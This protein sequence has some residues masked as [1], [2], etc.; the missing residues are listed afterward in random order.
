[1]AKTLKPIPIPKEVTVSLADDR[2]TFKGKLDQLVMSFPPRVAIEV[3]DAAVK[4]TG[5][6]DDAQKFVGLTRALVKNCITGVSQGFTKVLEIRGMGYRAQKTKDGAV[7]FLL[8]FSH[9]ID[10]K[11]PKGITIDLNTIPNPDDPK[12]Q[13]TEVIIKGADRELI[14][15]IAA[16]IRRYRTPDPYHGKGVRYKGEYV[17]KKAGKRA[18]ATAT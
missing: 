7:Q 10:L 8:G 5:K 16:N 1:M 14:G 18:V 6:G 9:P 3:A 2:L 12:T 15:E 4:V 13:I 11:P 17:R